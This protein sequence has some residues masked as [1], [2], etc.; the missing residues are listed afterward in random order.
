MAMIRRHWLAFSLN[1]V[2]IALITVVLVLGFSLSHSPR[3]VA[4]AESEATAD[5]DPVTYGQVNRL[6]RELALTNQ[7]LATMGVDQA[8]AE[9][10]LGDL[11]TW[12]QTN[13]STLQQR[14]QDVRD[15][16]AALR[17]AY[18]KVRIG[19]R[20][21]FLIAEFPRLQNDLGAA[22]QAR[23]TLVDSALPTVESR[24][25]S[26]QQVVWNA[27]RMNPGAPGELKYVENL[28]AE[29]LKDYRRQLQRNARP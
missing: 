1:F 27:A 28:T 12:Y 5:I 25:S 21:E 10:V 3:A 17:E 18:R 20:D 7:D 29:Q 14:D 19:L 23:R 4:Q 6:R 22:V 16:R 8:A 2:L 24:L 15:A 9:A 11:L 26:T 13:Q